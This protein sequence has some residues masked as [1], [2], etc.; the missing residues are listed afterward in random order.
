MSQAASSS[1]GWPDFVAT[2][3]ARYDRNLKAKVVSLFDVP[4]DFQEV[5]S[6]LVPPAASVE[7]IT[8]QIQQV[9][10]ANNEVEQ[11]ATGAE[12]GTATRTERRGK[13]YCSKCNVYFQTAAEFRE[14]GRSPWHVANVKLAVMGKPPLSEE[15]FLA[16]QQQRQETAGG[17][18]DGNDP[19]SSDDDEEESEPDMTES[20]AEDDEEEEEDESSNPNAVGAD[21]SRRAVVHG[22]VYRCWD[23]PDKSYT[24][25]LPACVNDE[26]GYLPAYFDSCH[27]DLV[28]VILLRSGRF[29]GAVYAGSKLVY[30]KTKKRYT[31]RAKAGGA[32]SAHDMSAGKARSAGAMLR[33]YGEK[34]MSDDLQA[35]FS[36]GKKENEKHKFDNHR[37]VSK[38]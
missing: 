22:L 26:I 21:G 36:E 18:G 1:T 33:R 29:A 17:G 31:V 7:A 16:I 5:L 35:I 37:I 11:R 23:V 15:D 25:A 34:A 28:G 30:S 14:H 6:H 32:Q 4:Q 2:K 38:V 24:F 20:E 12:E 10:Y 27:Q 3:K 19:V 9:G 13:F 8:K